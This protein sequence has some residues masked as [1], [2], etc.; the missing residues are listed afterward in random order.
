MIYD[1]HCHLNDP[2]MIDNIDYYLENCKNSNVALLNVI[3]Y[4]VQSSKKAVEIANKYKN[5]YAVVGMQPEEIPDEDF[6]EELDAIYK[7]KRI[8]AVGEIGLDY[9]WTKENK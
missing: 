2:A 1:T 3:G 9:H 6:Y 7:D 8:V 4:D 5:C